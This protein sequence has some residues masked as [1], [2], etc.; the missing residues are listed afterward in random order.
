MCDGFRPSKGKRGA[1]AGRGGEEGM[2]G[3]SP[4]TQI[5]AT[6]PKA[7]AMIDNLE[8]RCSLPAVRDTRENHVVWKASFVEIGHLMKL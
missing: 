1:K 3:I 5:S 8:D 2:L 7:R 4:H 6:T